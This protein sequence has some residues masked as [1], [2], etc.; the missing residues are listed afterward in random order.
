LPYFHQEIDM[1]A[2]VIVE[3]EVTDPVGYEDYKKLAPPAVALY[4]G[5]YLARGGKN[6][7]LEGGWQ[8]ERLVILKFPSVENAKAWLNSPEYAPARELRHQYAK[9]RMVVVE[10]VA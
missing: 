9:S 5:E 10:G 8:A 1:T 2:Y 7:A 3:V 6:E 4:G